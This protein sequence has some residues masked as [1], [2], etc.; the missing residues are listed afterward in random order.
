MDKK[1]AKVS[2][3]SEKK[4]DM[5]RTEEKRNGKSMFGKKKKK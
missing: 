5:S 2:K 3:K 1:S 4:E